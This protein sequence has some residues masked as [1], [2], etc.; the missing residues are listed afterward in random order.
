MNNRQGN[1]TNWR[2]WFDE[3]LR[4]AVRVRQERRV[5]ALSPN[6]IGNV[7]SALPAAHV[8]PFRSQSS[9]VWGWVAAASGALCGAAASALLV[10]RGDLGIMETEEG[11]TLVIPQP[12]EMALGFVH[13]LYATS[14]PTDLAA[15]ALGLLAAVWLSGS[16]TAMS[17]E[18][19]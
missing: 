6:F 3:R 15:I 9:R 19:R 17:L 16:R 18:R 13:D 10:Y 8:I 1:Q 12:L 4:T 5:V 7:M 2:G 11:L 14:A